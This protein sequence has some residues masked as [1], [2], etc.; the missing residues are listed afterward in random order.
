MPE[1]SPS[2]MKCHPSPA[3]RVGD[4]YY[5]LEAPPSKHQRL[6]VR[7]VAGGRLLLNPVDLGTPKSHAAI[8]YF[9]PSNVTVPSGITPGDT[10][11]V[12]ITVAGQTSPQTTTTVQ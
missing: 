12:S 5:Y 6:M 2:K 8:T 1:F 3:L 11:P 9:Q 10:V 4:K 7:P